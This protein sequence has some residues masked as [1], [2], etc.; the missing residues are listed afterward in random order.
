MPAARRERAGAADGGVATPL[1]WDEFRKVDV[2]VGRVL[3]VTKMNPHTRGRDGRAA[4]RRQLAAHPSTYLG[5]FQGPRLIGCVFGT[6]DSRKA[7][8]NR[9]A[10]H[11]GFR[12]QGIASRLVRECERRLR[13]QGMDMFAAL[14]DADNRASASLFRSMGY[15]VTK[16]Y[17]ARKK[18]RPGV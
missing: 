3:A 4:Y 7:W 10:V 11:P 5:A 18:R 9:L 8:I 16:L 14:I 13:R 6:H 15:D 1:T 12:R 2:R 17:Y